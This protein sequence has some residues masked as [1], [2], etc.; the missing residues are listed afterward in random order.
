MPLELA[1]TTEVHE[2]ERVFVAILRDL[3]EEVARDAELHR[4]R[5]YLDDVAI[6]GPTVFFVIS[7]GP[8]ETTKLRWIS[9][10]IKQILGF[11]A[12]D[13]EAEK[14]EWKDCVH[15]DD[16]KTV[17]ELMARIWDEGKGEF[18]YRIRDSEGRVRWVREARRV[19]YAKDGSVE[20]VG[21][22]E[23]LTVVHRSRQ[24]EQMLR[25]ELDHRVKNNL[26]IILGEC[27]KVIRAERIDREQIEVLTS[28]IS[29]MA[30]VHQVLAARSWSPIDLS[31]LIRHVEG[32]MVDASVESPVVLAGVPLMVGVDAAMTMATVLN[33]LATNATKYGGLSDRGEGVSIRWSIEGSDLVPMLHL[34]WIECVKGSGIEKPEVM[35]FGMQ[36][37][38]G[39]IPYELGGE[40]AIRFEPSG[41][42][43]TAK[44]PLDR[45]QADLGE[46]RLDFSGE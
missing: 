20:I 22:L 44:I 36:L 4:V 38:E 35:G 19:V 34:D 14:I 37:I 13:I 5:S 41:L 40:V 30:L 42:Q 45:F 25:R 11:D 12:T 16:L 15:P 6:N 2:N 27:G 31:D 43:F 24:R 32:A 17:S 33:E 9:P 7:D 29:S 10:N 39:M 21:S 8:D 18:E 28:R 26:Q 3:T 1:V 23:D 46:A